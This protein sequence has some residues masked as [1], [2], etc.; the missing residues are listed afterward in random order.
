[1]K[2]FLLPALFSKSLSPHPHIYPP[3]TS[4]LQSGTASY[5]YHCAACLEDGL[6]QWS[7]AYD[8]LAGH[9]VEY[10]SS[11]LAWRRN[12]RR[13]CRCGGGRFG[14]RSHVKGV[15]VVGGRGGA[16][17]PLIIKKSPLIIKKEH[18]MCKLICL[19]KSCKLQSGPPDQHSRGRRRSGRR[20]L[21]KCEYPI[22]ERAINCKI[23]QSP[24]TPSMLIRWLRLEFARFARRNWFAPDIYP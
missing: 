12:G 5:L 10:I 23:T 3:L 1:M 7:E 21:Q 8:Q 19:C 20:D 9:F 6:S 4:S 22:Q 17:C 2:T 14:G 11:K 16:N 24:R 18:I 13:G 15:A